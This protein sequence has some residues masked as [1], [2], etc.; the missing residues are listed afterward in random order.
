MTGIIIGVVIQAIRSHK[1]TRRRSDG[2][3][4]MAGDGS[5]HSPTRPQA[6]S[7]RKL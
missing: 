7:A 1:R 5:V 3:G 6:V 4:N 2:E